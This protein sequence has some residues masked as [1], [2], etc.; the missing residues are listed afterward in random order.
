MHKLIDET[1][2]IVYFQDFLLTTSWENTY[3]SKGGKK[4]FTYLNS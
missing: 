4:V 1:N 3:D 2:A